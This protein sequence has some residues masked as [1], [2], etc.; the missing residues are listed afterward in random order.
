M[1][2]MTSRLVFLAP[3]LFLADL[4]FGGPRG[5]WPSGHGRQALFVL[6]TGSLA[7]L[8][9]RDG[10]ERPAAQRMARLT[11]A[12]FVWSLPW[13]TLVP[14]WRGTPP[15]QVWAESDALLMLPAIALAQGVLALR[16]A[17]MQRMLLGGAA[18]VAAV[19]ALVWTA[20]LIAP[21]AGAA[22]AGRITALYDSP[23]VFVGALPNG[24]FRVLWIGSLWCLVGLFWSLTLSTGRRRV[25]AMALFAV[26]VLST[27]SRG[28]WAGAVAG[29]VVVLLAAP[30]LSP[31]R[32]WLLL[33]AGTLALTLVAVGVPFV[34]QRLAPLL[35]AHSDA[36]MIERRAQLPA[37]LEA[38]GE[39]PWLGQGFGASARVVRSL[40]S[41]FSY[42]LVPLALL[43]KMGLVG[44]AGVALF[45]GAVLHAVVRARAVAPAP[46][47]AALGGIVALLVAS[48]TNP[49]VLNFVGLG[50]A[51]ALLVQVAALPCRSAT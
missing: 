36:S 29:G 28:L 33:A 42:E 23:S 51:G 32:R 26:A 17:S 4:L 46:A 45:W 9:H 24:V 20:G 1:G 39:H 40:D 37:L 38:W 3:V 27:R 47:L 25:A 22:M 49:Y 16:A 30:H 14:W 50:V 13:A 19:H 48:A 15:Q 18:L 34:A 11:L 31:P 41:P 43:M 5:W 35:P 44:V 2:P 6:A 21:A 8:G 10:C 7:V 12:L